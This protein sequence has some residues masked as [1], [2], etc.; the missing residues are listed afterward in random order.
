MLSVKNWTD[1]SAKQLFTPPGCRLREANMV[2]LPVTAKSQGIL[3]IGL[4]YP[5]V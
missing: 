1:A 4:Q 5:S 3:G 2:G